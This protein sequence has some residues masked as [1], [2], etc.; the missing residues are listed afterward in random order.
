M[1]LNEGYAPGSQEHSD[2]ESLFAEFEDAI[3]R[4]LVADH[5]LADHATLLSRAAES[6]FQREELLAALDVAL[7]DLR[8]DLENDDD[9]DAD[10]D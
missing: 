10:L 4:E 9:D 6:A 8:I 3:V 7:D 2:E 5:R 1:T